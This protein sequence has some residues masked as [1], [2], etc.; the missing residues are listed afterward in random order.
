LG[1]SLKVWSSG[2]GQRVLRDLASRRIPVQVLIMDGD[3]PALASMI[4]KNLPAEDLESVQRQTTRMIEY[5]R[6]IATKYE[7]FEVRRIHRGMPHFQLIIT[8]QTAL[9]LQYMY[10]RGTADSP[11]QRFPASSQLHGAYKEEFED[12]WRLNAQHSAAG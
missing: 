5:F 10:S 7:S 11:L 6:D 8:E 9:V 3:N 12:L 1:V 2:D 4:N